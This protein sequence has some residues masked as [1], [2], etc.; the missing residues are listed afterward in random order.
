MSFC[1]SGTSSRTPKYIQSL[2]FFGLHWPVTVVWLLLFL[3]IL[4]APRSTGQASRSTPFS[5]S[6]SDVFLMI[7]PGLCVL[8]ERPQRHS[9]TSACLIKDTHYQRDLSLLTLT[10]IIWLGIYLSDYSPW[11]EFYSCPAILSLGQEVTECS[12]HLRR[13]ELCLFPHEQ[14]I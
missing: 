6:L 7:T 14:G 10:L 1:C 13:K 11:S 8:E 5:W 12:P 2:C 3:V 9:P 4:T